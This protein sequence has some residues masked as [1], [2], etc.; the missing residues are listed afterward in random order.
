MRSFCIRLALG[1]KMFET[2]QSVMFD[3]IEIEANRKHSRLKVSDEH[4]MGRR[5][6]TVTAT[7]N[8]LS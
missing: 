1:V 3:G 2:R 8:T 7:L 6:H 4:T 5:C